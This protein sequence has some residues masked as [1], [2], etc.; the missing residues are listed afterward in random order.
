MTLSVRLRRRNTT[1]MLNL[2]LMNVIFFHYHFVVRAMQAELRKVTA[3]KTEANKQ[4]AL[5]TFASKVYDKIFPYNICILGC[6][7]A[8]LLPPHF[9]VDFY[10]SLV[11]LARRRTAT[12]MI[13]TR[14]LFFQSG[15]RW[16]GCTLSSQHLE[17]FSRSVVD[18]LTIP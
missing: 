1:M 14:I 12:F 3:R 16:V 11:I 4:R 15:W 2:F 17:S 13:I 18:L 10:I 8:H 7:P 6:N 5:K 9:Q